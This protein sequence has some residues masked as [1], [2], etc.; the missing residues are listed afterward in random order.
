MAGRIR[1]ALANRGDQQLGGIPL[2]EMAALLGHDVDGVGRQT[3]QLEHVGRGAVD[4]RATSPGWEHL[5]AGISE[6]RLAKQEDLAARLA[7]YMCMLRATDDTRKVALWLGHASPATTDTFYLP[8]GDASV[9]RWHKA[10]HR[11][12][13]TAA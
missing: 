13:P 2:N 11:G 8:G 12:L 6:R 10:A 9:L 7:S 5:A 1:H 3:R 4:Q